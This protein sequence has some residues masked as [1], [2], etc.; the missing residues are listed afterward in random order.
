MMF[1]FYVIYGLKDMRGKPH[2]ATYHGQAGGIV[3]FG[4]FNLMVVGSIALHPEFGVLRIQKSKDGSAK[5][6][7]LAKPVRFVHHWL[8][9]AIVFLSLI[10]CCSGIFSK[11]DDMSLR[12]AYISPLAVM[13][14]AIFL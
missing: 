4:L 1:A 8:G 10:T 5:M 11:I 7:A 2:F 6:P 13:A 3:L 9:K 12:V 14:V